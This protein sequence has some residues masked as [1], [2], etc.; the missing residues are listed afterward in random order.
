[1]PTGALAEASGPCPRAGVPRSASTGR[2]TPA[3]HPPRQLAGGERPVSA[4]RWG[5]DQLSRTATAS[6]APSRHRLSVGA[7]GRFDLQRPTETA[8]AY[9]A[10]MMTRASR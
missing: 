5:M 3:A 6:A 8:W 2:L 9:P 4:G 7:I 10:K 1:M